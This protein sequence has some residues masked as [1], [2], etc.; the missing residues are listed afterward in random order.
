MG[1]IQSSYESVNDLGQFFIPSNMKDKSGLKACNNGNVYLAE[2]S[3]EGDSIVLRH[4]KT[5][6]L[7][8]Y[9]IIRGS[10]GRNIRM[11]DDFGRAALTEKYMDEF[12]IS[13]GDIVVCRL[14]DD[15]S[16]H[17]RPLRKI[18]HE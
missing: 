13:P 5:F 12:N 2:I 7:E 15:G 17:V 11:V 9:K 1:H 18:V 14:F 6:P 4:Y 3:V 16:I 10:L 8:E